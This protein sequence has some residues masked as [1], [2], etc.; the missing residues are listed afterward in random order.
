L[1]VKRSRGERISRHAPYGFDFG[2]GN[3]I[4]NE[5]E[6]E[7]LCL[8]RQM[9]SD[10]LSYRAIAVALDGK[11]IKPKRGVQWLHTSVKAILGR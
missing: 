6:Q 9:R 10:G 4:S 3:L 2:D 7:T 5:R 11:G 1:S 8:M